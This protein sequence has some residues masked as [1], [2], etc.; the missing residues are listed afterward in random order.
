MENNRGCTESSKNKKYIPNAKAV[1]VYNKLY[2]LYRRLHDAFGGVDRK[3]D[4]ADVM[5]KK[6]YGFACMKIVIMLYA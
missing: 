4:L 2:K 3:A 6:T 5:K 1:K